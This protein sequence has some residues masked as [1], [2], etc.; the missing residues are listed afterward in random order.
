M[1]ANTANK[2]VVEMRLRPRNRRALFCSCN[3]RL[4]AKPSTVSLRGHLCNPMNQAYLS[5]L[6]VKGLA[7]LY[8][9]PDAGSNKEW[10]ETLFGTDL[11]HALLQDL[12]RFQ[13]EGLDGL[14]EDDRQQLADRYASFDHPAAGEVAGWLRGEYAFD[15]ACLTD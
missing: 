6:P 1:A 10:A 2:A 12:G 15:P 8:G 13:D 11:A 3:Q 9:Q 5:M 4:V 7:G 14:S